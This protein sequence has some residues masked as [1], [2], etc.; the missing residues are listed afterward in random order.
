MGDDVMKW[1]GGLAEWRIDDTVYLSIAFTWK[2]NEAYSRAFFAKSQGLFWADTGL[3][4]ADLGQ[5][6]DVRTRSRHD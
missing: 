4:E 1:S 3:R 5:G 2:L 6:W